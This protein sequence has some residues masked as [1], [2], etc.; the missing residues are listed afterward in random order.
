[1]CEGA[2]IPE[3]ASRFRP[4]VTSTHFSQ[5]GF[6]QVPLRWSLHGWRDMLP[7][8]LFP[9]RLLDLAKFLPP[10]IWVER[11]GEGVGCVVGFARL[12]L[13]C[14]KL[15]WSRFEHCP[16]ACHCQQPP[17]SFVNATMSFS[18]LDQHVRLNS[19]VSCLKIPWFQFLLNT[20]FYHRLQPNQVPL[21][22]DGS[23]SCTVLI[24]S[25]ASQ[26]LVFSICTDSPR[27]HEVASVP[28]T[29]KFRPI[30]YRTPEWCHS[31]EQ[32]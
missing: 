29:I 27:C 5:D 30:W 19:P 13:S 25:W 28:L 11:S 17:C 12:F 9:L 31:E 18:I 14:W 7:D 8:G 3:F 2:L 24:R 20:S 23:P 26:T 22:A 10:W 21:S 16:E 32:P 15:H 6:V 1:M 4:R